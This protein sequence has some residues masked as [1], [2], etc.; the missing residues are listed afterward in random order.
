MYVDGIQVTHDPVIL[1][2]SGIGLFARDAD[3]SS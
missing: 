3:M 2:F 1:G